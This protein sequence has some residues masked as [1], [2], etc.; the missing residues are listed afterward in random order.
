MQVSLYTRSIELLSG[1]CYTSLKVELNS[2]VKSSDVQSGP[3]MVTIFS[4]DRGSGVG[5]GEACG[6]EE[7]KDVIYYFW[8]DG[9][10]LYS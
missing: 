2:C 1:R 3:G 10:Q 5:F 4:S 6:Y 8:K 9:Q 7:K